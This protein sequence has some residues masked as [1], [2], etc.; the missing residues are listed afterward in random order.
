MKCTIIAAAASL[1]MLALAMPYSEEDTSLDSLPPDIAQAVQ[2]MLDRIK[3]DSDHHKLQARGAPDGAYAV[4][5]ADNTIWR[6]DIT[7]ASIPYLENKGV[8]T[9]D[10][11]DPALKLIEFK[12]TA[13]YTETFYSY[14]RRLCAIDAMIC[15][16]WAAQIFSG[17][18][19]RDLKVHV[20]N[21]FAL[22]EPIP[23]TYWDG[24]VVVP[25]KINTP[26]VFGGLLGLAKS[27]RANGVEIYIV[28]ASNEELVRMVVSD[29]KYGYHIK[30]QNVIGVSTLLKNVE[31][32][33]LTTSRKQIAAGHY[34]M[35]ANLDLQFG[36]YL[37]TP[38]TWYAGK[39]AAI[40]TYISP[41]KKPMIAA[42][43]TP[44][45]D[46]YMLFN[47]D[48]ERGGMRLWI[49]K[50]Q[51]E[52]NQLKTLI[53]EGVRYQE[54]WGEYVT[55]SEGWYYIGPEEWLE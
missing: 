14:Y 45:S 37:W 24:D 22:T 2:K 47:V 7:E 53:A 6:Y 5:D 4:F 50:T 49:N 31:T 35:N 16:P 29:P 12:D 51:S 43:D 46:T 32:G 36:S 20:D 55:A 21:I 19:L 44:G 52:L 15:Y 38:A 30:P 17:L 10:K 34:D 18:T 54:K 8:I 39:W 40:Q 41:W 26:Q 23:T 11:L 3:M 13:D 27:L 25:T 1:V 9:R 28:S 48:V 42:G 33:E